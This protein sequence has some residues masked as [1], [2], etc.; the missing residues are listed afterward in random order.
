MIQCLQNICRALLRVFVATLLMNLLTFTCSN[1]SSFPF[2]YILCSIAG[3]IPYPSLSLGFNFVPYFSAKYFALLYLPFLILLFDSECFSAPFE[4]NLSLPFS[5]WLLL[6]RCH[7]FNTIAACLLIHFWC[8]LI[9]RQLKILF[10]PLVHAQEHLLPLL[11]GSIS[12]ILL[13]SLLHSS[14]PIFSQKGWDEAW[15][16]VVKGRSVVLGKL[17]LHLFK[18]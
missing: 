6:C 18:I 5:V 4:G 17:G 10:S 15:W 13:P 8:W 3:Y 2:H 1:S 12:S 16:E 7:Y 9:M 14:F 11:N